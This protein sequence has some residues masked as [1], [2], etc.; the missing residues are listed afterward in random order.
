MGQEIR[1]VPLDF[2]IPSFSSGENKPLSQRAALRRIRSFPACYKSDW[3]D[4]EE[5]NKKTNTEAVTLLMSLD[6]ECGLPLAKGN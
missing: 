1:L 4:R 6:R 3:G 2:S 5:K